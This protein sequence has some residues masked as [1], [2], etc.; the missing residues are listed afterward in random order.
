MRW[1]R[2]PSRSWY[3]YTPSAFLLTIFCGA[4]RNRTYPVRFYRPARHLACC[5]QIQNGMLRFKVKIWCLLTCWNHS[6]VEIL[7]FEP[8]RTGSKPVMLTVTLYFKICA[9]CEIRTH[10][11]LIGSQVQLAT[12]RTLRFFIFCSLFLSV[13]VQWTRNYNEHFVPPNGIGPFSRY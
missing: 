1:H 5:P 8:R 12:M 3:H 13:H 10:E 2:L 6:L 7:G 11:L 9:A 4:S